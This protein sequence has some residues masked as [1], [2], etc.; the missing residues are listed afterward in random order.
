M[1]KNIT[2]AIDEDLLDRARVLAAMRRTSVNAMVR[3]FL[4]REVRKELEDAK[5][6]EAWSRFFNE[7]DA[8]RRERADPKDTDKSF[9]RD[10]STTR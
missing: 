3:E 10:A 1:T 6:A 4:D 7:V 5:R 9:D 8:E 2:L